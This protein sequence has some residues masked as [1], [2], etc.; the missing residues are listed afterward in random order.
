MTRKPALAQQGQILRWPLDE[1]ASISQPPPLPWE[2]RYRP[3]L[4]DLC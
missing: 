1:P 4:P 2:T 3:V